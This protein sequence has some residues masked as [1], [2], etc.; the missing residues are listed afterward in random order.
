M[1]SDSAFYFE[2]FRSQLAN[3]ESALAK[4]GFGSANHGCGLEQ[5]RVGRANLESALRKT[6][7][8]LL[9]VLSQL[10]TS[11]SP[12]RSDQVQRAEQLFLIALV[13]NL[14]RNSFFT[15]LVR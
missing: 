11:E 7:A 1:I 14:F 4:I 12:A 13:P 9:G 5:I 15:P 3:Q 2:V 6:Q 10:D 8:R